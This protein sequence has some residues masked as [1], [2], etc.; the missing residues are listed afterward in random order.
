[1][2]WPQHLA[3]NRHHK[4][5]AAFSTSRGHM[6]QCLESCSSPVLA[7]VRSGRRCC[8]CCSTMERGERETLMPVMPV[9][10][11]RRGVVVPVVV[12]P[13]RAAGRA[14]RSTRIFLH[15]TRSARVGGQPPLAETGLP[16]PTAGEEGTDQVCR[17]SSNGLCVR[18]SLVT[19]PVVTTASLTVRSTDKCS[20]TCTR[21]AGMAVLSETRRR[22]SPLG[23]V[24]LSSS[25]QESC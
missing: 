18:G 21:E 12:E 14:T 23:L 4:L 2:S 8:R 13:G 6:T 15:T 20:A 1:M 9:M 17:N 7:C 10:P 3:E 22:D 25:C 5:V 19:G 24:G 11:A 16:P